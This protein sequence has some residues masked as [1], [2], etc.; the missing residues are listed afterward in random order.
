MLNFPQYLFEVWRSD[1]RNIKLVRV[2][3]RGFT[4]PNT[5]LRRSFD[6]RQ[7]PLSVF[8]FVHVTGAE[9]PSARSCVHSGTFGLI[10]VENDACSGC[11]CS[12]NGSKGA[13]ATRSFL[14]DD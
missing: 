1:H 12:K 11:F 5:L 7:I 6:T 2:N 10:D 14:G 3:T 13:M 8:L 9:S 4:L